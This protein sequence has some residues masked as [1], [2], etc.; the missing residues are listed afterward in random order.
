M[1]EDLRIT[2][3]NMADI[4]NAIKNCDALSDI[5]NRAGQVILGDKILDLN[6]IY[7]A[8]KQSLISKS[9]LNAETLLDSIVPGEWIL[10]NNILN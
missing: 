5:D 10:L 9:L 6:I 3:V 2:Y 1:L 8:A 7:Q 4:M